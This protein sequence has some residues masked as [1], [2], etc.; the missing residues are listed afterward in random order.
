MDIPGVGLYIAFKDTEGNGVG[1]L[2][3]TTPAV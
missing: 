2:Q 1:M 3:P